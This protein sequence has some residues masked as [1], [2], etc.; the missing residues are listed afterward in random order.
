MQEYAAA[1][2]QNLLYLVFWGIISSA[3]AYASGRPT[4]GNGLAIGNLAAL[5]CFFHLY[6]QVSRCAQMSPPMGAAYV[7]A[8]WLV[9]LSLIV[10][11]FIIS[12]LVPD[13][14][15]LAALAGFFSLQAIWIFGAVV[16][17]FRSSIY[18]G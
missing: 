3:L 10:L 11:V 16:K 13:I 7:Q 9:R 5:L 17:L 15:F 12:A 14:S 8:G 2:K 1:F 18:N 6:H 4:V